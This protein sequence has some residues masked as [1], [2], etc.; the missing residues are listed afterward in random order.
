MV[1]SE[2][3][4]SAPRNLPSFA[5]TRTVIEVGVVGIL[6]SPEG[7]RFRRRGGG[8]DAAPTHFLQHGFTPEHGLHAGAPVF[9]SDEGQRS[10]STQ[11][12]HSGLRALQT[13][14]P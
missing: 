2:P 10:S 5:M 3:P 6:I 11:P 9:S 12:A 1:T 14:R 4:M 7:I 13:A 8:R